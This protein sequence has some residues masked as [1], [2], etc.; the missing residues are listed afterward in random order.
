MRSRVGKEQE[1]KLN[2][3]YMDKYEEILEKLNGL[4]ISVRKMIKEQK[5]IVEVQKEIALKQEASKICNEELKLRQEELMRVMVSMSS[6]T[7]GLQDEEVWLDKAG[8]MALLFITRSTFYRR[9]ME[10]NWKTRRIGKRAYYL[11]SSILG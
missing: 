3:N 2:I 1:G 5:E 7:G 11:K 6:R 9:L 8:V 10:R 4:G